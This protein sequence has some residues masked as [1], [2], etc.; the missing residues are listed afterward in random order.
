MPSLPKRI[1]EHA[2]V[3]PE[4][5]PICPAALL[6]LGKRAAVDQA[7][8]RLA[9][10]GRLMRI[11]QGVYM[12]PVETRFG[13]C[14][15]SIGKA[16][17][18]LSKHSRNYGARAS[19]PAAA[20]R[21]TGW[22]CPPRIPSARYI[23]PRVAADSCISDESPSNCATPPAGSWRH[24][25]ARQAT[26]SAPWPGSARMR[27]KKVSKRSCPASPLR[28]W[29]NSLPRGRS[30]PSGWR[31]RSARASPMAET[32][33]QT[34]AADDRRDVPA[35]CRR[36]EPA[37]YIPAREGH[38]GRCNA[39]CPDRRSVRQGPRVQGRYVPVEGVP[40]DPPIL[41]GCRHH[42]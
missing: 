38:L 15:P 29:T 37:S 7:L 28:K 33:Y 39:Q 16:L 6:H 4:A 34:L 20:P 14:A 18:A 10:A 31:N 22:V 32:P 23:S 11:C 17:E 1:M 42:L 24:P 3:L 12:R 13:P 40:R 35:C 25:A 19:S 30:C 8:A 26:S 5:T 21:Q 36:Q 9:R 41:R 2:S 27:S